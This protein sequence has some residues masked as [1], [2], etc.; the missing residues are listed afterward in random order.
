MQPL[1][2]LT[3]R[4]IVNGFGRALRSP[5]RLLG[6]VLALAFWIWIPIRSIW[7]ARSAR[8]IQGLTQVE[9]LAR[10]M[11]L[12]RVVGVCAALFLGLNVL[13]LGGLTMRTAVSS[14]ADV[15]VLFP[16]PVSLR[17]VLGL[18]MLRDSFGWYLMPVLGLLFS[19]PVLFA[20][21]SGLQANKGAA[22][23]LS[24]QLFFLCF[25]IVSGIF[26]ALGYGLGL[27]LSQ[28]SE[29]AERERRLWNWAAALVGLGVLTYLGLEGYRTGDFWAVTDAVQRPYIMGLFPV[30]YLAT[31]FSMAPVTGQ[32]GLG[33]ASFGAL[34]ALVVLSV[35]FALSQSRFYPESAALR[36][37]ALGE[38]MEAQKSGNMTSLVA[39]Q[40]RQGKF[41][42]GRSGWFT[43]WRAQGATALLW[44]DAVLAVRLRRWAMGLIPI[45]ILG[46]QAAMFWYLGREFGAGSSVRGSQALQ[47]SVVITTLV[48]P[49]FFGF[50]M[51]SMVFVDFMKR[52]DVV[53]AFPFPPMRVVL[54]EILGKVLPMALGLLLAGVVGTVLF[55]R[56]GGLFVGTSI[57]CAAV[58]VLS[59]AIGLLTML[60]FPDIEDAAQRPIRGL[61]SIFAFM[62]VAAIVATPYGLLVGFARLHP[63]VSVLPSLGL[64]AIGVW[65]TVF[66]ASK[67][68][69][70]FNP[71]E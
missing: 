27:R 59:G 57:L 3:I 56:A 24:T 34:L 54:F 35:R 69:A 22:I 50:S 60:L 42:A 61:V 71:R 62:L 41:K 37:A 26:T 16:T 2:F 14:T 9:E 44:R 63:V 8:E 45:G 6:V 48:I 65:L 64:A 1:L 15:D 32:W 25:W 5:Q 66:F 12:D 17:L 47:M 4:Q 18:R 55:H 20:F 49:T 67:L 36:A 38:V 21:Q 68:Y 40:A 30:T 29:R 33:L 53:K 7:G 13:L 52:I 19:G 28:S 23:T 39:L 11:P 10:T 31:Q 58:V 51:F 46:I 70:T 43:G